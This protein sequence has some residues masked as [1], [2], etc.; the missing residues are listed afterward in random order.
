ME[1][2][3]YSTVDEQGYIDLEFDSTDRFPRQAVDLRGDEP[4]IQAYFLPYS[5]YSVNKL[6]FKDKI[7]KLY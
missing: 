4:E 1:I 3:A 6:K 5:N 7:G 2:T